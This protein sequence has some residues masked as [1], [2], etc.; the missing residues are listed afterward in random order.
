MD[1]PIYKSFWISATPHR[2]AVTDIFGFEA[3]CCA[4]TVVQIGPNYY[5]SLDGPLTY[6]LHFCEA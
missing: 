5:P 1:K 3:Q 4:L 2:G 6:K